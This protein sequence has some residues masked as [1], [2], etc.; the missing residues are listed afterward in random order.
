MPTIKANNIDINYEIRGKGFP[1]VL[2]M[3]LGANLD[4]WQPD[5]LAAVEKR[6][7]LIMFDNRG[8]GRSNDPGEDYTVK[9]LADDAVGLMDALKIPKAHVLGIS[10][11]GMI[12]QEF[13]INYPQRVQKLVLAATS[14]G[15]DKTEPPSPEAM[16]LLSGDRSTKTE[17]QNAKDLIPILYTPD[18][19]KNHPREIE[20]FMKQVL[21]APIKPDP[22]QR[23]LGAIMSFESGERLKQVKTPTLVIH[24]KKDILIPYGNGKKISE[25]I[26]KAKFV[27]FDHSGHALFSEEKAVTQMVIDFLK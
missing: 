11:G 22:Y 8:A 21:K 3:G 15:G 6:F 27:L 2:I 19:P 26:P 4:W 9:T 17:E 16:E 1:L 20:L 24:G 10:L 25:L 14:P 12:A 13:A 5:F 23:Q 18:F 7:K